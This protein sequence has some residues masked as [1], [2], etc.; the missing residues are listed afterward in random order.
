MWSRKVWMRE[1]QRNVLPVGARFLVSGRSFLLIAICVATF[2]SG[3]ASPVKAAIVLGVSATPRSSDPLPV[4]LSDKPMAVD[5]QVLLA[6]TGSGGCSGA[7]ST[8]LRVGGPT[9]IILSPPQS[10]FGGTGLVVRL[11]ARRFVRIENT[12]LESLLEPPK[13]A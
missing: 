3:S 9:P 5:H 12:A 11:V 13:V 2:A 8:S 6:D 4:P 7:E 10:L 1:I